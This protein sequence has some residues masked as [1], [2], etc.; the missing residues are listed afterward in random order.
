MSQNF[1]RQLTLDELISSQEDFPANH[2]AQQGNDWERRTNA[3]CGQRCCALFENAPRATSWAKTFAA[4]LVGTGDWYSKRCVL[5]WKLKGT[6]FNR[7]YFQ[8]QVSAHPTEE[9]AS[10]L[11]LTPTTREEVMDSDKFKARMQKYD[12]GT[13][14]P[15]LATQVVGMLPTPNAFDYNTPRSQEAWD[16]AK[17]KHGSALQN[18]L[19]QMASMGMLPTPMAQESEKIT[20]KENQ[21]SLTKR[22][23]LEHG[24]TS[25]LSPLFVEEMMGFPKNWT[26]SPFQSGGMKL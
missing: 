17:K 21:D 3:T 19:K 1:A 6:P 24:K 22:A 2:T 5:T 12:N 13:T 23:R 9:I 16:K 26:E 7:S 18:P 25:Q 8:L 10:G 11:L 15:N 4:W 14:V 20:G